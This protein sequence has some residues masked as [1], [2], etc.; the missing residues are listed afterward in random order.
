V[1]VVEQVFLV[2]VVVVV[3]RMVDRN[4]PVAVAVVVVLILFTV[5]NLH[6]VYS[7]RIVVATSWRHRQRLRHLPS[8][9]TVMVHH[10]R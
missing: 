9:L 10:H 7:T 6:F 8:T 4:H 3:V 2:V 1:V 5:R